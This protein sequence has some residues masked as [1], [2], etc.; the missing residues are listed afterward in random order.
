[1]SRRV[2][3]PKFLSGLWLLVFDEECVL[4]Q[5]ADTTA[6]AYIRQISVL[7]KAVE[8]ECSKSVKTMAVQEY[9]DIDAS[10]R[11]PSL[12][13]A[14]DEF[15]TFGV[16]GKLHFRDGFGANDTESGEAIP[17]SSFT[18][19][20]LLLID[21]LQRCSD[22][23]SGLLGLFDPYSFTEGVGK[24]NDTTRY[25]SHGRGAVSDQPRF[26]NRYHFP[27]WSDRLN[28]HFPY[29]AFGSYSFEQPPESVSWGR[30]PVSKLMAVRKTVT[31]P[32][33]IGSE[34]TSN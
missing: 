7:F 6:I 19:D 30:I 18:P 33:L 4:R 9:F 22:S 15:D 20:Q 12:L 32:R 27:S 5:D 28:N 3:V 8:A 29:D 1:V 31:K 25:L 26:G 34:T 13:W 2:K 23:I 14:D 11:D 17:P 10:L 21:R 24:S 16:I